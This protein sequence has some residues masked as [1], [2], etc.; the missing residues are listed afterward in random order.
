MI[1]KI[2][3]T[4][5][6]R[7][8]PKKDFITTSV[9]KDINDSKR[10]R[11]RPKKEKKFDDSINTKISNHNKEINK[12]SRENEKMHLEIK[13]NSFVNKKIKKEDSKKSDNFALWLLI[14]SMILFI[15]SLYKTFYLKPYSNLDNYE[16][17]K[18]VDTEIILD[19][20]ITL[21]KDVSQNEKV[22]IIE[23]WMIAKSNIIW[24]FYQN[25]NDKKFA[26]ISNM[27]DSYLKNSN[28]FRTYYNQ[29]WLAKFLWNLVNEKIY[30]TNIEEKVL[31]EQKDWVNYYTY[32]IKY[33]IKDNNE[34]FQ[35]ERE[36][37]IVTK[38]EKKL[39]GSLHCITTWC[40]KMPFFNLPRYEQ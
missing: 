39:I 38:N 8:R 37:A 29:N 7:G 36:T 14:F 10:W 11:G 31:S 5:T 30:V 17:Q 16:A 6:N 26:E 9:K 27:V 28:V 22:L 19:T 20:W 4:K 34:L 15:F 1:A 3:K 2:K 35:E 33:K 32:T 12:I 13:S 23:S 25:I 21:I 24:D 40:S 18:N